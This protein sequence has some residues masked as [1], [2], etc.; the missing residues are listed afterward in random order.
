MSKNKLKDY[1]NQEVSAEKTQLLVD[2]ALGGFGGMFVGTFVMAA[3]FT[4]MAPAAGIIAFGALGS[5]LVYGAN[6]LG[7]SN[8]GPSA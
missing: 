2:T 3:G 5:G 7:K 1:F 8:K 6:K 4:L